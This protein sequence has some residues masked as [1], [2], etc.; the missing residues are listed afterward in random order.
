MNPFAR[1]KARRFLLQALYEWQISGNP[2]NEIEA[3]LV[4]KIN[5]KKVDVEYFREVLYAIPRMLDTLDATLSPHLDRPLANLNPVELAALRIGVYELLER[6]D[7]PYRVAIN[8]AV[9]VTKVFGSN[10][11]HKYVNG[12]LDK[13]AKELRKLEVN[14]R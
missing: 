7:I 6:L 14:S 3:A 13:L 5:A 8:E 1:R 10:E 2:L 9:E 12:V 4:S 11:G